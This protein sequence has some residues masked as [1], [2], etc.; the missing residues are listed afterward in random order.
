[1]ANTNENFIN[2]KALYFRNKCIVKPGYKLSEIFFISKGLLQGC[3]LSPSL[4]KMYIVICLGE[5]K[6]K[7]HEEGL[8]LN[9]NIFINYYLQVTKSF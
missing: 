2:C 1:M 3:C 4:L 6:K 7:C 9:D 5:G 8:K